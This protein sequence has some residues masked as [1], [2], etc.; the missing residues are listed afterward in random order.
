MVDVEDGGFDVVVVVF[1]QEMIT[2]LDEEKV[3]V[4]GC[5][6]DI[7]ISDGEVFDGVFA[8]GETEGVSTFT[9]FEDVF[10]LATKEGVI[11]DAP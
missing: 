11:P 5:L 10:A 8:S 3:A 9:T 1:E 2:A 4:V 7:A 6:D